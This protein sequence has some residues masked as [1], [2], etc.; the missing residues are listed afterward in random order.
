MLTGLYARPP[1]AS[2]TGLVPKHRFK[3]PGGVGGPGPEIG[4]YFG[5]VP[6]PP[7]YGKY[8]PV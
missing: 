8:W 4:S 7:K 1:F 6:G 3:G 5:F 2:V